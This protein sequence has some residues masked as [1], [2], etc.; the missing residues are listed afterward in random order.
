MSFIY[1][2]DDSGALIIAST[3]P[4]DG[5]LEAVVS[6]NVPFEA[7]I[8]S[9]AVLATGNPLL[10]G[11]PFF[12]GDPVFGPSST[13]Y[14]FGHAQFGSDEF[15]GSVAFENGAEWNDGEI[16]F[17][18][19]TEVTTKSGSTLNIEGAGHI[20]STNFHVDDGARLT[21][22][23]GGEIRFNDDATLNFTGTDT[24]IIGTARFR[25]AAWFSDCDVQFF[26]N[27]EVLFGSTVVTTQAGPT[28][29]SGITAW[30]AKRFDVGVDADHTYAGSSHDIIVAPE[31]SSNRDWNFISMPADRAGHTVR[32]YAAGGTWASG[33][34]YNIKDQGGVTRGT[35]GKEVGDYWWID[36][37]WTG[38]SWQ[39]SA[40]YTEG[41][42]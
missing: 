29:H 32:I 9:M 5:D 2:G 18:S 28:I 15:A 11:N 4:S 42:P 3:L 37:L 17:N 40:F 31:P 25:E 33:F 23:G 38:G 27:T 10:A 20:K 8:D 16:N 14:F 30:T 6:V 13:V 1:T 22:D 26:D 39:I 24:S 34:H 7:L 36:W 19:G 21:V 12:S 35:I 41:P